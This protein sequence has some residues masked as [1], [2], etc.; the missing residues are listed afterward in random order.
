VQKPLQPDERL[1]Y[2]RTFTVPAGWQGQRI[3]LH[4]GAADYA[5]EVW[6]NGFSAG[7]H[8]GGYLP[9]TM[10]ITDLL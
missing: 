3:L 9:F 4:F 6:I 5:C 8:T 2:R 7:S 10:D 1:W